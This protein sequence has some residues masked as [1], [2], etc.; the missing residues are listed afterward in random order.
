MEKLYNIANQTNSIAVEP[1]DLLQ[2]LLRP[3]TCS[4]KNAIEVNVDGKLFCM[5]YFGQRKHKDALEL[6]EK[7]NAKLPLPTSI[8]E[9]NHFTESFKRLGINE[10]MKDFPMKIVIDVRRQT[11]GKSK[12]VIIL[13]SLSVGFFA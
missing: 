11:K 5:A 1:A 13:N 9:H 12:L 3:K 6:C 2:I 8:T 4:L 7:L 10:K